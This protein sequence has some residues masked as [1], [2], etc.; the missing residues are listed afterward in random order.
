MRRLIVSPPAVQR[1]VV[2]PGLLGRPRLDRPCVCG[3]AGSTSCSPSSGTDNRAGTSVSTRS[4]PVPLSWSYSACTKT[5]STHAVRTARSAR[6]RGRCRTATTGPG[7]RGSSPATTGARGRPARCAPARSSGPTSNSVVSRLPVDQP[8]SVP[9]SQTANCESTPRKRSTASPPGQSAG[10]SKV[11]RYSPVGF[12]SGTCG[13]STGNGIP[14][15]RV[16]GRA[17][18]LQ[19]PVP[20]HRDTVPPCGVE[21]VR[22]EVRCQ[23]VECRPPAGTPTRRTGRPARRRS[24]RARAAFAGRRRATDRSGTGRRQSRSSP[25]NLAAVRAAPSPGAG[26]AE[27]ITPAS[28]AALAGES[29]ARRH[30]P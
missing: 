1:R 2:E 10:R 5:S 30:V 29:H 14:H 13:G 17:V 21:P 23:V 18:A 8:S 26:E 6:R 24:G 4:V 12:S 9:L 15:V 22:P 25:P 20:G 7:P 16:R 11:V 3:P 27:L 28:G 19:L